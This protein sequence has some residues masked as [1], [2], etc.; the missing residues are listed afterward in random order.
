MQLPVLDGQED[1][2]GQVRDQLSSALDGEVRFGRH[3]RLLYATDASVYQVTPI[4]VV[5][6]AHAE[7]IRRTVDICRS[8]GVPVLPRGA[9]TSLSGQTVNRAVVILSL[10]HI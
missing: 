4:G 10:I 6:P 9:G 7:D 3:D 5:I 8:H 2:F 1:T